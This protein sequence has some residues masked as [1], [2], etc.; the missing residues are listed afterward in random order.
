MS[1][2]PSPDAILAWLRDN[3]GHAAKREIARAFGLKGADKVALK[4]LLVEM[5]REGTIERRRRSVRPPR[6][7]TRRARPRG[8]RRGRGR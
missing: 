7:P 4:K 8:R 6:P 5:K 3:P 2:L 1:R